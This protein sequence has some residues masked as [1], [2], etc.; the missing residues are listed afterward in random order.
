MYSF[1]LE[2]IS[3]RGVTVKN[4]IVVKSDVKDVTEGATEGAGQ[5]ATEGAG[6]DATEDA[7]QDAT[8]GAG[9]D[10][11]GAAGAQDT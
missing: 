6:Q 9:Q 10:V 1:T 3:H 11:M 2:A 5:G 4:G 7:G 8:E